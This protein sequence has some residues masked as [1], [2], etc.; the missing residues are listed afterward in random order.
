MQLDLFLAA[1]AV[2]CGVIVGFTLGLVGGGGSVL[3]V[4]LLLY[5][6]GMPDPHQ[7]IGTSAL[8]VAVNAFANLVPHARARHVRWRPALIFAA[9]GLVGALIGSSIGKVRHGAFPLALNHAM[10]AK[11]KIGES[12]KIDDPETKAPA[13]KNPFF[14]PKPGVLLADDFAIDRLLAKGTIFGGCKIALAVQSGM[15]AHNAGV[16]AEEAAK[17]W[18]ANVIPGITL[19]P[20]GTWGVS[21]AQEA[22]CTYCTGG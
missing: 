21:R 15:L 6:V 11:Y 3:A 13:V 20:S 7:A 5:V 18:T 10:W 2:G 22:G 4:P 19:V 9:A 14:Q 16:S 12:F 8:S 17:E 1:V